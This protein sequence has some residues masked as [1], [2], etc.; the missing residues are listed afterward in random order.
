[1][2]KLVRNAQAIHTALDNQPKKPVIAKKALTIQFPKRFQEINL[3][4][5][6]TS[7][8]VYGLFAIIQGNNYALCNVNALLELGQGAVDVEVINDVEYY[9]IHYQPGDVVIKTKD[10]VCRSNLIFEALSEFY[11]KAKIPWYVGYEDM[12]KLFNTAKKHTRTSATILPSVIEFL[13]AYIARNAND[14]TKFVRE[15][16]KNKKEVNER[17]AW[18]PLSSVYWS[19]PGTVNKLAGAY[20]ADGVIS[21]LVNPSE[22][23]EKIER[24]L[25]A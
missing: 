17:L 11:F 2:N 25:R 20:F 5:L 19:A 18:V 1:M 14:R 4:Q 10:L 16:I 8:F 15:T 7:T 13:T 6:G 23:V 12:G 3:A 21:A 22:R 24:I 9:N